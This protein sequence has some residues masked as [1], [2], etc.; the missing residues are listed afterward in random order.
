[1]KITNIV[2]ALAYAA[3][4]SAAGGEYASSAPAMPAPPVTV[5]APQ[6]P[7]AAVPPALPVPVTPIPIVIADFI[8]SPAPSAPAPTPAPPAAYVAGITPELP[9][10]TAAPAN[11]SPMPAPAPAPGYRSYT[12]N[13]R[14]I[15]QSGTQG[16]VSGTSAM[17]F[18]TNGNTYI[19]A[20]LPV[21]LAKKASEKPEMLRKRATENDL[22]SD[23]T[24]K[25][26]DS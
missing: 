22:I 17:L 9:R 13:K 10:N 8:Y 11:P 3:A 20:R 15:G 16:L 23:A 5:E 12:S 18:N 14:D 24:T 21:N 6:P 1:M 7:S 4:T 2:F 26:L 25:D 19:L